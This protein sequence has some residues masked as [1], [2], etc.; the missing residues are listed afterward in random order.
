MYGG[1]VLTSLIKKV[2]IVILS[3]MF[4]ESYEI[5]NS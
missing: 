2:Q 3:S 5:T 1:E 4:L